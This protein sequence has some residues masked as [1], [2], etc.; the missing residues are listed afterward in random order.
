MDTIENLKMLK[1]FVD[2]NNV[3]GDGNMILNTISDTLSSIIETMEKNN[4]IDN[5]LRQIVDADMDNTMEL[6][7]GYS[8]MVC[9]LRKSCETF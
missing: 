8:Q 6:W 4:N 1:N 7:D 9:Q 5:E 2:N 3:E